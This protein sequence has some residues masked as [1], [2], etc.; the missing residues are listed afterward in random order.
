MGWR[1]ENGGGGEDYDGVRVRLRDRSPFFS[2]AS[3]SLLPR[4]EKAA[5]IAIDRSISISP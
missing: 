3:F 5:R 2:G 1:M 4:P